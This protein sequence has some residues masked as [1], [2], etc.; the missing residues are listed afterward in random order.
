MLTIGGVLT[1]LANQCLPGRGADAY[2]LRGLN[3]MVIAGEH[4]GIALMEVLPGHSFVPIARLH[5]PGS[6]ARCH[7]DAQSAFNHFRAM[8]HGGA[9]REHENAG[10]RR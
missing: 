5:L 4:S 6:A 8:R 9:E 3:A 2:R 10:W 7:P 1:G